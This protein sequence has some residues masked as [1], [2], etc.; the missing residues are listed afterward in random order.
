MSL[1]VTLIQGGGAG[2]DQVPAV[3]RYPG[4]GRRGHPMEQYLAGFAAV[5]Q[6]QPPLPEAML[7]RVRETGLAL[8]T[9]LLVPPDAQ[10][11]QLQRAIPAG[12]GPVR[13]G[14]AAQEPP[15]PAGPLPQRRYP[16][17][18]R[19]HRGPV[20][21]HRTRGRARRGAEHQGRHRNG[22]PGAFFR[23]AFDWARGAWPQAVSTAS[24][25][26]N[27]L[28]MADG[29][30]LES[31]RAAAK[32]Y[33]ELE[34]KEI[35]VD[36][37][38]MQMVSKPQQFDVMVMGNL[39]GDIVSDLAAGRPSAASAP[40]RG[41][42][43]ARAF[44]CTRRSTAAAASRSASTGPTRCRCYFPPWIC[45]RAAG[46]KDR[47]ARVQTAVETVLKRRPG[48]NAGPWGE[49][50][51]GGDGRGDHSGLARLRL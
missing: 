38:C 35:I 23:F 42:T 15:R 30:I 33:P 32:E 5:E 46:Q 19:N 10:T 40:R 29:L 31:F 16:R 48:A 8:K 41:S 27:I 14:P 25:K 43:S 7:R 34:T 3:Q 1:Q 50:D 28:K 4:G 36:N 26:A 39:Y 44:E 2:F 18:P 47:A 6:G 17:H 22:V 21:R 12:A 13:L 24:H 49:C 11:A 9:K 37:C 51:D 20:R 45:W